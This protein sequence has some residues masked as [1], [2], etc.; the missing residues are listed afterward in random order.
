MGKEEAGVVVG[1]VGSS[2]GGGA[3]ADVMV[4][5]RKVTVLLVTCLT[6]TSA[7]P[8]PGLYICALTLSFLYIFNPL[9]NAR[10]HFVLFIH[11]FSHDLLNP[12]LC[13]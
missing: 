11:E 6:L 1:V 3:A 5:H 4:P 2:G 9:T 10:E 12:H 7:D 8:D 13:C